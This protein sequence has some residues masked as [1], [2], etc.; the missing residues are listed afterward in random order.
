[1]LHRLGGG[2]TGVGGLSWVAL[3]TVGGFRLGVGGVGGSESVAGG[4]VVGLVVGMVG[5]L[6][7]VGSSMRARW[8][9]ASC[10]GARALSAR[11][12]GRWWGWRAL[13]LVGEGGGWFRGVASGVWSRGERVGSRVGLEKR[14]GWGDEVTPGRGVSAVGGGGMFCSGWASGLGIG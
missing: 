12:W 11:G 14:L 6:R 8:Y 4:S 10:S 13:S 3:D 5:V 1:M 7:W 9:L 2:V